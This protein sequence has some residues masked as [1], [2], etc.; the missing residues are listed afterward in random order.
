MITL[1]KIFRNQFWLCSIC[2][3]ISGIF[4]N[5]CDQSKPPVVHRSFYYWKTDFSISASQNDLLLHLSVNT[6]YIKFF[7][8]TWEQGAGT[9]VPAA[10]I[11]NND[12]LGFAGQFKMVPVIFITNESLQNISD[13]QVPV[14]ASKMSKHL[15]GLLD[16]FDIFAPQEIQLDCDWSE[17]TRQKYFHLIEEMKKYPQWKG[18]K[19]SATI[20]L[21][22]VKYPDKTGIPPVDRG[23]L[24]FYNMGDIE[25]AKSEN[26]IFDEQIAKQYISGLEDYPLP[27]DAGIA[28]YSWGL[29]FDRQKLLRIYY[30]LYSSDMPDSLFTQEG[31]IYTATGN[32]YFEGSYLVKGNRIRVETMSPDRSQKSAE[33]LAP[34]FKNDTLDVILY[35]LDSVILNNYS[36]ADLENIYS[37]FN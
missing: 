4:F 25:N 33:M 24:M 28:C 37:A 30:P 14:L 31:N 3:L 23:M 12:S 22:Q 15:K 10:D 36:Y 19:W 18:V 5:S 1:R 2:A 13:L 7:D 20:R 29:L 26:S 32:F 35:H 11:I 27:L 17:T 21:H 34:Y 6:L 16:Q 8:V 9:A